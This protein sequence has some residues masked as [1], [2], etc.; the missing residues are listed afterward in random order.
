MTEFTCP[1][2]GDPCPNAVLCDV[3]NEPLDGAVTEVMREVE[4]RVSP[5]LARAALRRELTSQGNMLATDLHIADAPNGSMA[6]CPMDAVAQFRH[7]QPDHRTVLG[8]AALMQQGVDN[9]KTD[10][11]PHNRSR[12]R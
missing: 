4:G 7:I 2:S 3:V 8:I 1:K 5:A 6:A 11:Q 12:R 10:L 9:V